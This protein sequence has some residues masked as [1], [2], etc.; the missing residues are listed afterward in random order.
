MDTE[1]SV[2]S[3]SRSAGWKCSPVLGELAFWAHRR[4][5]AKNKLTAEDVDAL[6]SI[7]TIAEP[8]E[9]GASS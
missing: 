4:L 2:L 6:K 8:F 7:Q 3:P 9:S 1:H 5:P